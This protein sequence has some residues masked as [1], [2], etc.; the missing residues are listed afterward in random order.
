MCPIFVYFWYGIKTVK[1]DLP[2]LA[3][4]E[5]GVG[6]SEKLSWLFK[7]PNEQM[8]NDWTSLLSI[9]LSCSSFLGSHST[10]TRISD[11]APTWSDGR[12]SMCN[13]FMPRSWKVCKARTKPPIWFFNVNI[14]EIF[15]RLF[16]PESV[17]SCCEINKGFL[18]KKPRNFSL[19]T[20]VAAAMGVSSLT[21]HSSPL[22]YNHSPKR[23]LP[24]PLIFRQMFSAE[25]V[26]GSY[27]NGRRSALPSPSP[28]ARPR[29]AACA[30][31]L[32]DW[33][34]QQFL[35]LPILD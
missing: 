30:I 21:V 27:R 16:W 4:A 3:V 15:S 35:T 24:D 26:W 20:V 17:G 18:Q 10:S 29:A 33:Q 11:C 7:F 34:N 32:F 28:S 12:D 22:L 6:G 13:I 25:S 14:I 31:W 9:L 1:C 23:P 2:K 8:H 19:R 5:I